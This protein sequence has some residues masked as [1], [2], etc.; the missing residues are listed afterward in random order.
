MG[1]VH[2]AILGRLGGDIQPVVID[3]PAG[4]ESNVAAVTAKAV[5]YFKRYLSIDCDVASYQS[6]ESDPVPAIARIDAA[7]FI[8]AG[9][10]S[11]TYAAST[12]QDS[13]VF[14]RIGRALE[15]GAHL[16]FASAAG[17][18]SGA[19]VLPVYEIY[20][21]GAPLHWV[22][23]LGLLAPRGIALAVIPHWNNAEGAGYDTT[24]CYVGLER[25]ERLRAM[26]PSDVVVLGIDEHTACTID[27]AA[28][29]C[30]VAGAGTVTIL[31]GGE[32]TSIPSGASFPLAALRQGTASPAEAPA[33]LRARDT[34]SARE[35]LRRAVH[36]AASPGEAPT[37]VRAADAHALS[38][39]I[40]QAGGLGLDDDVARATEA[41]RGLVERWASELNDGPASASA[42][43][44]I[45]LLLDIRRQLREEKLWALADRI[46]D[47]LV[48]LGVQVEDRP[49]TPA[50]R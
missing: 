2:R 24:R 22:D 16:V 9:P 8:F 37:A 32:E 23:G 5:A 27:V 7:N 41:L 13:P 35:A 1:K 49:A 4:F 10:G 44:R 40:A 26:L 21:A 38:N 18:A 11:P 36:S 50:G 43:P 6:R 31:A 15:S 3:T 28:E 14:Q 25:F 46:R 42:G 47:A 17:I 45:E 48:D 20:K 29:T 19:H 30:E 33:H 12:W 39:A 34:E